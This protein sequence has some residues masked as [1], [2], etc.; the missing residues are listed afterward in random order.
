MNAKAK[1]SRME[2]KTI[3]LLESAG[4]KC[5]RSAASLG[6]F[7]VIAANRLG[8]RFIQVKANA[9]P[10][11]VER[12]GLKAAANNLPPNALIECWRWDDYAKNPLIK[13][14]SEF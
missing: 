2:Y 8:I 14:I 10:G 9:W 6:P 13:Q 7:D 3:H 1:G 11:P 12:E 4:Y 5:M